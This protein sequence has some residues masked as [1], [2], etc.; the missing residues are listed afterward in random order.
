MHTTRKS[1][2]GFIFITLLIDIMGWGLIIPVMADLIAQLKG[3]S[4]N[5]ASPYGALLLSVFAITQFVFAPVVGNLS[6]RFGRRPILLF[7]LLGFGIDYIILALAPTYGWLFIGRV[8]AGMTGASF[9]TA[10]AYIADV[11][12]DETT[13]AKNFGMI[14]AAFGLGFVLGPA[15]GALLATWGI[16]APFYAAAVLCL[17]NCLYGLFILPESL[18]KENRRP[19]EWKRANPFGSLNFL[20]KH[21]EIGGLA[22][23]FF[24]IYLGAQSVQG[25]WNFFTIYRFHWSETMVGISLAV[26]GVLV[27]GVQAGLTRVIVPKIGN[28]KSIYIGLLLYTLGLVLFA[29][30]T[31]S[32][33]M[34][35]FLIPYCLGGICGPSL[36]SV[37]SGHVPRNQQGELQGALTSLMS[38][39]TVI[40]PLIMNSSFSYF[41]SDKAPFYFP[42]IHFL[43]GAV[44]MLLSVVITYKVM[45][46]E[47]KENPELAKVISG[48]GE[49]TDAP[50][51]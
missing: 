39:T 17:L 43:I 18:S 5:E 12:P 37:I 11:S 49:L 6:D 2:I 29:F 23:S 10:T 7:S 3:I 21:P 15:L 41:T 48:S 44:C 19:F 28:E 20:T 25:N 31:Q 42:G 40:G 33:M 9:T 16:R 4:V 8:I 47:K 50:M 1:A 38:L 27:G 51:H 22:I 45:T 14:G 34:F 24:L 35:A 30:A 32:W 36:Q 13:R 46:R 26:V